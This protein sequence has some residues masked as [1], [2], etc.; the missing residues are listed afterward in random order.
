MHGVGAGMSGYSQSAAGAAHADAGTMQVY[1]SLGQVT[2]TRQQRSN[3]SIEIHNGLTE[4]ISITLELS[5]TFSDISRKT[6]FQ[7]SST[8][9][10][11]KVITNLW[12]CYCVFF[13]ELCYSYV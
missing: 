2:L 8:P 7:T 11:S 12:L 3:C 5:F 6:V 4:G 13:L 10:A 1:R 9:W